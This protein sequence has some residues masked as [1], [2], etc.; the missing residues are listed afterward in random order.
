M[1]LQLGKKE[2]GRKETES[3]KMEMR[4]QTNQIWNYQSVSGSL[5]GNKSPS[6]IVHLL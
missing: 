1:K 4:G 5:G 3:K 2:I 6:E